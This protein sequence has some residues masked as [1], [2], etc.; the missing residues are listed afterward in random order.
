MVAHLC[1]VT[2]DA[3]DFAEDINNEFDRDSNIDLGAVED[4]LEAMLADPDI[5]TD[6]PAPSSSTQPLSLSPPDYERQP[7]PPPAR[8][9]GENERSKLL[10]HMAL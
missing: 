4:E 7:I 8:N 2:E 9:S 3:Q 5:S 6:M 1:A 10:A